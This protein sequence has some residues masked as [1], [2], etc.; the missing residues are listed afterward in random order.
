MMNY[1]P[2][3]L[4]KL[5]KHYNY[6]QSAIA[7]M[8]GVDTLE[9]MGYENG[10]LIINYSQMEKLAAFY[11][12][13][14]D[15][16][17]L[18]T[19]EIVMEDVNENTD[20]LNLEYFI[21]HYNIWEK[22]LIFI[23]KYKKHIL[24]L[25]AITLIAG[26]GIF[27]INQEVS[28]IPM[29]IID[30]DLNLLSVSNTT[31]VY[32]DNKGGVK[33]S[34]DDS[35]GQLYDLPISNIAKV[36]EGAS[37]TI[38]LKDDGTLISRG[39]MEKYADEISSWDHIVDVAVGDGHILAIDNRGRTFCSGDNTYG[40][41]DLVDFNNIDRVYAAPKGS[42][43]I[44]KDGKLVYAGEIF[45]ISRIKSFDNIID[46]NF[47]EDNTVVLRDDNTIS[48]YA[49]SKS[50]SGVDGWRGIVDVACGNDF[51]AALNED[52]K[53]LIAI[54]NYI[55]EKEVSSWENIK[56]I[57][58]GNDYLIAYDGEKIYGIGNNIYHQFEKSESLKLKLAQV[59]D[60]DINNEENNLVVRFKGV[61]NASG[62]LVNVDA[63]IGLS[64]YIEEEGAVY[65]EG[66]NF[67]DG[68]AYTVSII[69]KGNDDYEDSNPVTYNFTY[70][71]NVDNNN[72][73]TESNKFTV[74]TLIGKTKTN[75]E[76][77]FK[78]LDYDIS[79]LNGT[80]VDILCDGEEESIVEV[81]GIYEGESLT[82]EELQN[83]DISYTYCKLEKA[84]DN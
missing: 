7:E 3:K 10:R 72:N 15:D 13:S 47:S 63:G 29:E 37:F 73:N 53:V 30:S 41:C 61:S 68:K 80:M 58:A 67:E 76:A 27:L 8:L 16:I 79:K 46:I 31:V 6:S 20:E 81:S 83:R 82:K 69:S 44:N 70:Q 5:R 64:I 65:F 77:Y 9:Y 74:D 84:N 18:N 75:F 39:L 55:I 28:K 60:V 56:T 45:G 50:F 26:T 54:D 48:Y 43:G 1:L 38:M 78:G 66:S 33:G 32:I 17:F 35:N 71:S 57:A 40:Q 52:G 12:I 14:I 2:S 59:S 42:I 25:L 4:V 22:T 23:K 49:K 62:Y 36:Q 21:P 19:D 11:H 34:G 24:S 51:I